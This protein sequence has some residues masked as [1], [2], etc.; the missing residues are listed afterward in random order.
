MADL[1]FRVRAWLAAE[2]GSP[3][4]RA[5]HAEL[6]IDAGGVPLTEVADRA[7]S[8]V[9]PSLRVSAGALAGWLLENR[10]RI[11]YE[12]ERS[13]SS[14]GMSHRLGAVG[15]GFA[16]PDVTL[17]TD[18][19][20]LTVRARRAGGPD[21][22]VRFLNDVTVHL[23]PEAYDAAVDAFVAVVVDRLHAVGLRDSALA[24][25][26][27]DVRRDRADPEND[28]LRIAEARLGLDPDQADADDVLGLLEEVAWAGDAA[29][30]EILGEATFD[31]ASEIL[32][33]ARHHATASDVRVDLR[34]FEG[35]QGTSLAR[36]LPWERGVDLAARVR[37]TLGVGQEPLDLD[38]VFGAHLLAPTVSG[39][40][41]MG[42]AVATNGVAGLTFQ[43]RQPTGRRFEAA[44]ALGDWLTR[45]PGDVASP[46]TDRRTARQQ[47][48][49]AFAAELLC[50]AEGIAARV[51]LPRPTDDELEEAAAFYGVSEHT[52]RSHLVNEGLVERAYLPRR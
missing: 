38:D 52:V 2:R 44:R 51:S 46:L 33:W 41:P 4:D 21:D 6:E 40:R 26:A 22:L 27:E 7:A 5:T 9:R 30:A 48:Q 19:E 31:D 28:R 36:A 11:L 47:L 49:R 16:W 43:R 45:P 1:Q 20:R 13:G 10:W 25:L 23:S 39:R 18:G 35:L 34:A 15:G 37:R 29:A 17:A 42:L 8:S 50:P 3:E 12:P 14:W 24:A 32:A